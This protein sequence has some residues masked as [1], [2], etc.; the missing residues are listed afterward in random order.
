MI[1]PEPDA[2]DDPLSR[3]PPDY[4]AE[5]PAILMVAAAVPALLLVLAGVS[6]L[7]DWGG[8]LC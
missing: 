6:M 7:A 8:V 4:D 2:I 5:L 3:G 1:R